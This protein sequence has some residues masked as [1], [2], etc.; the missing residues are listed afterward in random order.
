MQARREP[1]FIR[2]TDFLEIPV[3]TYP[4]LRYPVT[5]SYLQLVGKKLFLILDKL[6]KM[7]DPLIFEF[8][9][10]DIFL[11]KS[12]NELPAMWQRLYFHNHKSGGGSLNMFSFILERLISKKYRFINLDSLYNLYVKQGANGFIL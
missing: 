5:M 9:L 11:T 6:F 2:D 10:H 7:P 3:S 8:H 1:Y 4:F 12:V